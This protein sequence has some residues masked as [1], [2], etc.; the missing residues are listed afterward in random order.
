M[1]AAWTLRMT[2]CDDHGRR[3]DSSCDLPDELSAR[4]LLDICRMLPTVVAARAEPLDPG[5]APAM[6]S[7]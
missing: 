4:R 5:V 3:H 1:T 2:F 6:V 7:G